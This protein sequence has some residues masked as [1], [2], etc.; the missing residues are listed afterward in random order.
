MK[1]TQVAAPLLKDLDDKS[2]VREYWSIREQ[3]ALADQV[4]T[5]HAQMGLRGRARNGV[6]Q[7][8]HL[9][10]LQDI[11][12][13]LIRKRGLSFNMDTVTEEQK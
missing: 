7:V 13:A 9:L 3:V 2:L 8:L 6:G 11:A 4:T 5:L 10:K 12:V 1:T